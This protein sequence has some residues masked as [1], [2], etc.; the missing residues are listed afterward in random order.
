MIGESIG[1]KRG[2]PWG[3]RVKNL[4]SDVGN[5]GLILGWGSKNPH[6]ATKIFLRICL[7][8]LLVVTSYYYRASQVAQW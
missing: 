5:T 4:T 2:F 3:S 7:A 8:A 1:G 6:E